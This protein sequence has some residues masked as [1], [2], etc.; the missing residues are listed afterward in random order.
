[1]LGEEIEEIVLGDLGAHGL[2]VRVERLAI[3]CDIRAWPMPARAWAGST[4]M[5]SMTAGRFARRTVLTWRSFRPRIGGP[6]DDAGQGMDAA[7]RF[8]HP[9]GAAAFPRPPGPG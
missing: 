7:D 2:D 6:D 1:M 9:W 5:G 3:G 8:R 4:P